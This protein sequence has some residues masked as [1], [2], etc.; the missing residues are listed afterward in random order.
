MAHCWF[1]CQ[2]AINTSI[3]H[4]KIKQNL[5]SLLLADWKWLHL[6]AIAFNTLFPVEFT[7]NGIKHFTELSG[8]HTLKH[9]FVPALEVN[10]LKMLPQLVTLQIFQSSYL[11][12]GN[13]WT[14]I[15]YHIIIILILNI[16][17]KTIHIL[18]RVTEVGSQNFG[19]KFWFCT[20]LIM[21]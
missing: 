6:I 1:S 3:Q 20:R 19:Y 4:L 9:W 7:P 18:Q 11:S 12:H 14:I 10:F 13:H 16:F 17:L 15:F 8:A 21:A 5:S 2:M